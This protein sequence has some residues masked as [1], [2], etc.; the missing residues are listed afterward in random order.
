VA[1]V[2]HY[3]RA[4]ELDPGNEQYYFDL[5]VEYLAHFTFDPALEVFRV[6]TQKFPRSARQ[7]V[8]MG[9]AHYA[10]RQYFEAT[11]AFLGALEIDP[12]SSI[13]FSAWNALPSFLA[14]TELERVLPRLKRLAELHP[15]N[16][17]VL[18]C[19]GATLFRQALASGQ[20]QNFDTAK[21]HLERAVRLKPGFADA[22]LELGN[23]YVARKENEKAVVEF[24][25][26]V[27][28]NPRSDVAHY[29]LGQTC[30][31]TNQLELAQEEL[32]RYAELTRNRRELMAPSR[33]AIRQFIL[34]QSGSSSTPSQDKTKAR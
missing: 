7:F 3:Q 34:A 26:A 13:A 10:A 15:T 27:R 1:A 5:G 32:A 24:R 16:A 11:E 22:H 14:A 23:L 17:E 30:R 9:L 19:Y 20:P 4:V 25:E 31:N 8:G 29:R 33:S 21:S 28:W 6:G 18:Y 12:S 2:G